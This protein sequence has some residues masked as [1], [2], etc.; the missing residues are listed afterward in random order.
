MCKV[1]TLDTARWQIELRE[2]STLN[3]YNNNKDYIKEEPFYDNTVESI[4]MFR[5][6]SNTLKWWWRNRFEGEELDCKLCN[7]G[8]EETLEYFIKKCNR[9]NAIRLQYNMNETELKDILLFT[10]C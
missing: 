5:A 4:L 7:I 6:R 3:I 10:E 2:K 9:L 1:N 8:E